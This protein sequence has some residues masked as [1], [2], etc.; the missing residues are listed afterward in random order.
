MIFKSIFGGKGS[1]LYTGEK[2]GAFE[3]EKSDGPYVH[4]SLELL[5]EIYCHWLNKRTIFH[6]VKF[7]LESS[8]NSMTVAD[9]LLNVL[10]KRLHAEIIKKNEETVGMIWT[11]TQSEKDV[12]YTSYQGYFFIKDSDSKIEE[13]LILMNAFTRN[14][15]KEF[16]G[17][18]QGKFS[19]CDR[20]NIP[21][22]MS[23]IS[24]EE[25]LSNTFKALSRLTMH[26]LH[27]READI[28]TLFQVRYGFDLLE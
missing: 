28:F 12:S 20:C 2:F 3:L 23:I 21:E 27:E 9:S 16:G 8:N 26:N 13:V 17:S 24:D 25:I 5:N 14:L 11:A 4:H 15:I 6:L 22:G 1:E 7:E 19:L 18:V 10:F